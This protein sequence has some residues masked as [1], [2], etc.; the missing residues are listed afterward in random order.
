M[1]VDVTLN[2]QVWTATYIIGVQYWASRLL[3]KVGVYRQ[4][5]EMTQPQPHTH[6]HTHKSENDNPHF[7]RRKNIKSDKYREAV[8][9][10]L[11]R[12]VVNSTINIVLKPRKYIFPPV[13]PH[14]PYGL[15]GLPSRL[16]PKC[17]RILRLGRPSSAVTLCWWGGWWYMDMECREGPRT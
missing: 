16:W 15:R 9:I 12:N 5:C 17:N 8:N 3:K 11:L 4:Q 1:W 2:V 7:Q 10:I 14:V 6:T 13:P